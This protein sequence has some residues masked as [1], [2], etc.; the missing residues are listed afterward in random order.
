MSKSTP[1]KPEPRPEVKPNPP[2]RP[3]TNPEPKKIPFTRQ[4]PNQPNKGNPP[5]LR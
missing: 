4:E 1:Q 2:S 3:V 5:G